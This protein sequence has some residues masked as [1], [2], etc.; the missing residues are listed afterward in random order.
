MTTA[1]N[2]TMIV[3]SGPSSNAIRLGLLAAAGLGAL[4]A[5]YLDM[6]QDKKIERLEN[7]S[8]YNARAYNLHH[9]RNHPSAEYEVFI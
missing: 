2:P 8:N 6:R 4:V 3:H 5:Y 7:T 1:Y 9:M